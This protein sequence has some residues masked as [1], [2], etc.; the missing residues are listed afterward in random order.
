VL[1]FTVAMQGGGV[2]VV[3]GGAIVAGLAKTARGI[4]SI[5]S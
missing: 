1:S 2:Y 5:F 4:A 3:A